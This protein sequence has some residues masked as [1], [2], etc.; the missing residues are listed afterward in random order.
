MI[1][2]ITNAFQLPAIF[3]MADKIPNVKRSIIEVMLTKGLSRQDAKIISDIQDNEYV[4][5]IYVSIENL[6]GEN[7]A[8]IH[9]SY[10]KPGL[11]NSGHELLAR[12]ILW[13]KFLGISNIVA[14]THPST[15]W[16]KKNYKFKSFSE[17]IRR[18]I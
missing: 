14:S 10:V 4:G 5:F 6:N 15:K 12:L 7:V 18:S 3:K 1:L 17:L 8:F 11:I 9:L 16:L 2:E 13:S